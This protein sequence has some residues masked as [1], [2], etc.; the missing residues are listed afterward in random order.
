M[1]ECTP[2]D[3]HPLLTENGRCFTFNSG[4]IGT[5]VRSTSRAGTI[6]GLSIMMDVQANET[7]SA[8]SH[9]D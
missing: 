5:Q 1:D 8:N 3:F 9:A 6:G 7:L 2:D 4:K